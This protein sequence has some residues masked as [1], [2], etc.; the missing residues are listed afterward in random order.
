MS[1]SVH[2]TVT[3]RQ[4]ALLVEESVRTGLSMAEL[5]RRALDATYRPALRPVVAGFCVNLGLTRGPDA[6]VVG[7]LAKP[8]RRVRD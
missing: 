2:I 6:A 5:V 3:D 8:P 7:R 4:H 1:R